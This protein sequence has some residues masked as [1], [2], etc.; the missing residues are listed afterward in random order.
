MINIAKKK[1]PA[2]IIGIL[3]YISYCGASWYVMRGNIAYVGYRYGMPGWF[4]NDVFAFFLGGLV[5]FLLY[6]F[7]SSYAYRALHLKTGGDLASIKYGL[8]FAVIA[9]NLALFGLKFI[10]LE[11][12][13]YA[14]II[15]VFLDP[16]VT[17]LAVGLYMLY[18]FYQNYVDKSKF[19]IVLMQVL[20]TFISVYAVFALLS[21]VLSAA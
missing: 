16:V 10:Y 17:V 2:P 15:D 20:G 6:W 18:A 12:P 19:R 8:N 13:L 4:T 1:L 21:L 14:S 5:P 3:V 11:F 7:V 9:A